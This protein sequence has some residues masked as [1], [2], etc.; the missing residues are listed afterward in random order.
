MTRNWSPSEIPSESSN[1][2]LFVFSASRIL[3][4]FHSDL[5]GCLGTMTA[6][7]VLLLAFQ[8]LSVP[9]RATFGHERSVGGA[10]GISSFSKLLHPLGAP[11][12]CKNLYFGSA[13]DGHN[14]LQFYP[15]RDAILSRY[16][17][18][19]RCG[20]M[21]SVMFSCFLSP[22][23]LSTMTSVSWMASVQSRL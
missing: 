11:L 22:A 23:L 20:K 16:L 3:E 9:S 12:E 18:R 7:T 10:F 4:R 17:F 13:L 6:E 19:F 8:S 21:D 15:R 14:L 5:R 2:I 1:L